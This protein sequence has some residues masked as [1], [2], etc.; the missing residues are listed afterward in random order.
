MPL[1]NAKGNGVALA[2]AVRTLIYQQ[3]IVP[4]GEAQL[5]SSGEICEGCTPVAMKADI[6]G[7]TVLNMVISPGKD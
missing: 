5:A 2:L 4:H 6:Q 1:Q 7:S 3:Q